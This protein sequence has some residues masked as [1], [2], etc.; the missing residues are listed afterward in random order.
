MVFYRIHFCCIFW[1]LLEKLC[2]LLN[3]GLSGLFS[4]MVRSQPS[5]VKGKKPTIPQDFDEPVP[6]TSI[7]LPN[8]G[9]QASS[10][11]VRTEHI[12]RAYAPGLELRKFNYSVFDSVYAPS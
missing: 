5:P 3:C 7:L 10:Y 6:G 9:R 8:Y 2:V 1:S 11:R 4:K 12:R